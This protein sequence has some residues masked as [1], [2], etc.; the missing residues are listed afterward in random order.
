MVARA[1]RQFRR[2]LEAQ[3]RKIQVVNKNINDPH[4]T[5]FS[6]VVIETFGKKRGLAAILAFNESAH[7]HIPGGK[8]EYISHGVF[9]QVRR[10]T[11]KE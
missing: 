6:Y 11:G 9:T 5:V 2:R 10:E 4:R 3:T 1:T 8:P 7:L